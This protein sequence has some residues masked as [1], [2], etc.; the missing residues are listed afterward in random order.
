MDTEESKQVDEDQMQLFT[1]RSLETKNDDS[2]YKK[3]TT[4]T[5]QEESDESDLMYSTDN[6]DLAITDVTQND[7]VVFG[8][9]LDPPPPPSKWL[10][11]K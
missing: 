2:S 4:Q 6:N 7:Q 1:Q 5:V 10:L 3:V 8:L 9:D 11:D